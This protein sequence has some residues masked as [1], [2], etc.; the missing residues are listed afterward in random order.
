MLSC[1][2]ASRLLSD[3]GDRPLRPGERLGL[4]I[5]L[6]MCSG[7]SRAGKQL[8]FISKAMLELAK[9]VGEGSSGRE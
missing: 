6:A 5:H 4:Q 1:R 2:E 7:C 8:Q 9:R 3:R